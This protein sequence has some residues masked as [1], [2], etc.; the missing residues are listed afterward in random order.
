MSAYREGSEAMSR[1]AAR[2]P[3]RGRIRARL[4]ACWLSSHAALRDSRGEASGATWGARRL[5]LR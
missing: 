3:E 2:S 1:G 5:R 4:G